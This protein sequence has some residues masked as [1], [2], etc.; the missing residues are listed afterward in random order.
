MT[1]DAYDKITVDGHTFDRITYALFLIAQARPN[2]DNGWTITQGS[3]T[4]GVAQ[5]GGT[6]AG[7]GA[8]DIT[9]GGNADQ[10][11]H[12]LRAVGC[13]AWHRLPSEGDW[14]EHIH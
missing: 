5:S 4:T 8:F 14:P 13:A 9:T 2:G 6:H 3:Y 1:S 10:R 7:G 11:V 12:A